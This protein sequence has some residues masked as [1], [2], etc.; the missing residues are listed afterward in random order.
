MNKLGYD[1]GKTMVSNVLNRHG[2]CLHQNEGGR[3]ATGKLF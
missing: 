2:L 3:G 1:V